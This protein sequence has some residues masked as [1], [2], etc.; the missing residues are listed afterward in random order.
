MPSA[1][2]VKINRNKL[3]RDGPR[4]TPAVVP[5]PEVGFGLGASAERTRDSRDHAVTMVLPSLL[6][7]NAL[8]LRRS[9]LGRRSRDAEGRVYRMEIKKKGGLVGFVCQEEG[10]V[11]GGMSM[12]SW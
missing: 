6:L 2:H 9:P 5:G 3:R 11:R 12:S 4:S 1:V 8:S 10:V 7:S